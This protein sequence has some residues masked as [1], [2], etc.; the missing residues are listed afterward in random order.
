MTFLTLMSWMRRNAY[1]ED[2]RVWYEECIS[3]RFL[4]PVEEAVRGALKNADWDPL[5]PKAGKGKK[6]PAVPRVAAPPLARAAVVTSTAAP[7]SRA[8]AVTGTRKTLAHRIVPSTPPARPIAAAAPCRKRDREASSN[9][10]AAAESTAV[11]TASSE[12]PRKRVLPDLS[13]DKDEEEAPLV[14]VSE[15]PPVTVRGG[16][17]RG[18]DR[19]GRRRGGG[20]GIATAEVA[21]TL[22][23]GA[24]AVEVPVAEDAATDI[25]DD[26]VIAVEPTQAALVEVPSVA[27]AEP[28]SVITVPIEPLPSPPY[29]PRGIVFRSSPRSSLPLSRRPPPPMVASHL[30]FLFHFQETTSSDDLEE[31]YASL[32]EEGGS[33]ALAPLDEDSRFIAEKLREFLF[34]GVYQ[35]TSA[36]A[37]LE[38]RSCLDTTM[39]MVQPVMGSLKEN[40]LRRDGAVAAGTE[41][42]FLARQIL[43]AAT[44]KKR[45]L[46]ERKFIRAR[47]QADIDGGDI[48]WRRIT[49]LIWGM[50][51]EVV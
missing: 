19:G 4:R 13:E 6:A 37:F 11:E 24:A 26:E 30:N 17:C 23:A 36:E 29:R 27:S 50:F 43:K 21:K 33:S 39:A 18:D 14:I 45:A 42:K 16:C 49:C 7:T 51:S 15:A 10:A 31:L 12:W 48:A 25:P 44:E 47:W 28:T 9:E 1:D 38:F 40:E 2:G 41:L 3:A 46:A 5:L 35:M 34:F 8:P 32:H 22:D 20:S